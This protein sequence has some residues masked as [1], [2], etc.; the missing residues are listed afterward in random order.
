MIR[1]PL[2]A[3]TKKGF[4]ER[5]IEKMTDDRFSA[6]LLPMYWTSPLTLLV[7]LILTAGSVSTAEEKD[8]AKP[9]QK[10][11]VQKESVSRDGSVTIAG[12]QVDYTVTTGELQLKNDKGE[13]QATI[14]HVSYVKKGVKDVSSRPV[15]FAFNGGPGSSAVWL[16]LGALGPKIIPTSADGTKALAPPI[17]VVENPQSILDVAD[18]VFVD[19]VATGLSRPESKDKSKQF[20]GVQGDLDSMSDF[21]RRWITQHKRWSSPKFVLG[22][23]Y[24]SL[25]AAGLSDKLQQRYGMHL[26]GVILLSGLLDYRTLMASQGNDLS[27]AVFLPSLAAT[28][29]FHGKIKG[30][31][32]AIVKDARE[33]AA[34]TYR[35]ALYRGHTIDDA[36]KQKIATKL[37]ELTSLDPQ[38]IIDNHLRISST[39]FRKQLLKSEGKV[40]GRFD[41]RVAWDA[42]DTASDYPNYDPSYSVVHGPISTAMLDYLGRDLGWKDERVYEILTGKVHP[43]NWNANNSYVNLSGSIANALK[44]NPKLR[45]L[46][47]CGHTDLATAAG[48][49]LYSIDHLM[50]PKAQRSNIK[51]AWYD[52]GHMFYLNQ[53][54]LEKMRKDLVSFITEK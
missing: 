1:V 8:A 38:W 13:D 43:W 46:V 50:L 42:I 9:K 22:E 44:H 36:T 49:I 19:P 2:L 41:A 52:A 23:S 31:R 29:H 26:N 32:D 10:E 27:Y 15:L 3:L 28:A 51:T 39:K 54:D 40:L 47:Q 6:C 53:P 21:I 33:F 20:F 17:T 24:G 12:A 35:T 25:R 34:T 14:F 4:A 16:H 11:P 5:F 37:S 7:G 45:I 18:L 30:D 48:G